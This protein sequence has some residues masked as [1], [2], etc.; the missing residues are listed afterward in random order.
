MRSNRSIPVCLSNSY[1][2]LDPIGISITAVNCAG[3]CSPG[4]TSCQ[5]WVMIRL[6]VLIFRGSHEELPVLV[7]RDV[8][9]FVFSSIVEVRQTAAKARNV[10]EEYGTGGNRGNREVRERGFFFSPFS[11]FPPVEHFFV[12]F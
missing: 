6:S 9:G 12:V 1:L 7:G 2:T 4:V 8:L 10:T 3:N 11:L 5:A